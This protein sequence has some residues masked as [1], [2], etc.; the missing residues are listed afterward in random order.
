[1]T[2][3]S[4]PV[5]V[6]GCG[7]S[8][9]IR[10]LVEDGYTAI[11]AVDIAQSALDQLRIDLGDRAASV[12]PIRADARTVRLPRT[13]TLW[14]DRATFHFLTDDADQKA[15]AVTAARSVRAGGYLVL[16]E[17]ATDGPTS[18][19][20]L[21]VARHSARSLQSVFSDGFELIES[22]ERD[23]VTPSGVVQRFVHALLIRRDAGSVVE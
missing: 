1:M 14:H 8:T 17:F 15:Y 18:C 23:H 21:T 20:G 6:V 11:I 5:A 4:D 16:A 12:T 7:S 19:S 10:E 13:V 2:V 3:P 22:F 9:L